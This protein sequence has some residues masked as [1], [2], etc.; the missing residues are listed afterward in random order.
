MSLSEEARLTVQT[1]YDQADNRTRQGLAASREPRHKSIQS[2]HCR[3]HSAST[4]GQ[5][6]RVQTEKLSEPQFSDLRER[7]A[8]HTQG[9]APS[10]GQGG[11]A[12]CG[13]C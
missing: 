12:L 6:S 13:E 3:P 8:V 1:E 9:T 4:G 10:S 5:A 2:S 7:T 11:Q